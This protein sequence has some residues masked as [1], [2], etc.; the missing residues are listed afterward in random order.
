MAH[1]VNVV[2][3]LIAKIRWEVLPVHVQLVI[4]EILEKNVLIL[5]NVHNHLDLMENVDFRQFVPIFPE[6]LHVVALRAVLVIHLFA[7]QL[8]II[9]QQVSR[10]LSTFE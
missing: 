3:M 10:I 8:F 6:V 7:V 9:V 1:T 4:P 2:K 5:M